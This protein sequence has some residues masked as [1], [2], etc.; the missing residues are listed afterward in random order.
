M[1]PRSGQESRL[2]EILRKLSDYY[3]TQPGYITGWVL[4]PHEHMDTRRFGRVGVWATE[5]DAER[6]AQG[7]HALALR[8]DLL[9]V[10]EEDSHQELSFQG[11]PDQAH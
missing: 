9:R 7:S 1:V 11:E 5:D 3:V 8:S 10:V 6:A 2:D 4:A